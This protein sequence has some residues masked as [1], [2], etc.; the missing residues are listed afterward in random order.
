MGCAEKYILQ[1][2]AFKFKNIQINAL[3]IRFVMYGERH[4][5]SEL[6]HPCARLA[7]PAWSLRGDLPSPYSS[8]NFN[9][10]KV[11]YVL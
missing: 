10:I 8:L 6:E 9:L 1:N 2:K 11:Y 4:L 3:F 7:V 5:D